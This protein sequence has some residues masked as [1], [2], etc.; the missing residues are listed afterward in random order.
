MDP[1]LPAG[2]G[3]VEGESATTRRCCAPCSTRYRRA[4]SLLDR[5]DHCIYSNHEFFAFTR[6]ASEA[7]ARPP[8]RRPDR[9]RHLRHLRTDA[10]APGARRDGALGGLDRA[11]RTRPAL[12]ARASAC[13]Y[14]PPAAR[15]LLATVV[16]EPRSHR[17]EAARGRAVAPSSTQLQATRGAEVVRSSTMRWPHWSRPTPPVA[18]SSSTPPPRRMFERS[19]ASSAGPAG[20]R[21]HHSARDIARP[22]TPAWP[23]G[24]RRRAAHAAAS[25][26][27]MAALRADGSEFPVE[28]VLWRTDRRRPSR[29]TPRRWS[30]S[31]ARRA[32]REIER[33]REALRQSEKLT[34]MGSLLAGVAHELNNPLAIVMGRASLLE[35]KCD[36]CRAVRR[37]S[38]ASARP[39]SAAGASFAPSSAW[40]ARRRGTAARCSI[41]DMVLGAVEHA[42]VQPA[43]RTASTVEL[44]AGRPP[45]D[46]ARRRRP[47]RPSGAEPAGER[48]PGPV[49]CR[50]QPRLVR[51]ETG[52]EAPRRA[53]RPAGVAACGGQRS[54]HR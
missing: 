22:T 10:R 15:S 9:P 46:G 45:A 19:R 41:N 40:R 16:I 32:A 47:A 21:R 51:V 24:R 14:G 27:E 35:D 7:G 6:P 12:H 3:D 20:G 26:C 28:M 48:A 43:Q 42:A 50:T 17:P 23:P 52:V 54:R 34:A 29:S 49:G 31:R 4:W 30:T 18:S 44:A 53:A 5:D 8:R 25:A 39:P 1:P 36:D 37:R 13:R 38:C 2:A 33:Q 11:A